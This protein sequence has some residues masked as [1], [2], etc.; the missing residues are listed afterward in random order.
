M[1][2]GKHFQGHGQEVMASMRKAHPGA[3]EQRITSEFY[4]TMNKMKKKKMKPRK[5][6]ILHGE[7]HG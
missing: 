5:G 1:P 3:S 7:K 2:I 6:A 4:A